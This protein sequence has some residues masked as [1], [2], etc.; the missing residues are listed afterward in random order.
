MNQL[1]VLNVKTSYLSEPALSPR[2]RNGLSPPPARS[3]GFCLQKI[4]TLYALLYNPNAT[5]YEKDCHDQKDRPNAYSASY[6]HSGIFSNE[7][8]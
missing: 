5:F 8:T 7:S 2:T 6:A 4:D 1:T 3:A